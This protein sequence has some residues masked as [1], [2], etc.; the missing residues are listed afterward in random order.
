MEKKLNPMIL[1]RREFPRLNTHIPIRFGG[2]ESKAQD[3]LTKDVGGG[4]VRLVSREF[5]PVNAKVKLEFFLTPASEPLKAVGKVVWVQ[6]LPYSYQHDVGIQFVDV[7]EPTRKR[8]AH[9]VDQNLVSPEKSSPG[10]QNSYKDLPYTIA[11]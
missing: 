11:L 6:K 1:G 4:G 10:K 9:Y 8:I 5:L 3:S 7:P 2:E